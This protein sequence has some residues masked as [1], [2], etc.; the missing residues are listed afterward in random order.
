MR[1]AKEVL[2]RRSPDRLQSALRIVGSL[3]AVATLLMPGLALA[4]SHAI[5]TPDQLI[6]KPLIP[7]V[8]VAVVSG[9]PDKRG[10][11]YVI[12]IRTKDE[13]RV[14]PHWHPTDEHV[15]VLAGSFWMSH[16][17]KYDA[18]RLT[19]LKP[20][21]HSLVPA[22]LPHFGLHSVG[23]VIEVYGEAPFAYTFVNPEDDP[24]K[25]KKQ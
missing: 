4:Q 17:D 20:G 5:T 25:A 21:A 15:T 19:E 6:W 22:R 23:N 7:G 3:L 1:W 13:V 9:D 2:S 12:R 10:G 24:N 11:L 8:E 14:P 16:G 18:S